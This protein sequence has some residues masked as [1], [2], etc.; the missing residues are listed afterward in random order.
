MSLAPLPDTLV[1]AHH[2]L[3]NPVS[4]EPD[5]GY[6]WLK[7]IGAMKPFGDP[8][9]IQRDY[10]LEEFRGE[11]SVQ[12]LA[13]SVHVQ[14]DGAIADPVAETRFIQSI[15]DTSG[16]PIAIVGFVDLARDDAGE[17][18][19]RHMESHNFRGLRQI[20]SRLEGRRDIS[21]AVEEYL[22]S[23]LWRRNYS[24]LAA[25]GLTFDLQCYPEQMA[26]FAEFASD[27]RD[28]PVVIDHAGSPYDQSPQGLALWRDG[29]TRLAALPNTSVKL[30]GFGMFDANWNAES[31]RPLV[32]H[33]DTVFGP[34]RTLFGSNFPVDRLMRSY[35]DI[36]A[37]LMGLYAAH[38]ASDRAAVF[39]GN[40]VRI[41]RMDQLAGFSSERM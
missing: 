8:T 39:G 33:I 15:S 36:L 7:N 29:M 23:P 5:V 30:S 22:D 25:H 28:I 38:T 31:I 21:F 3:W 34:H 41:Y 18:I 10:L 4:A 6:I 14:C 17:V 1:D 24:S 9:P 13:G 11:S 12:G 19:D 32:E 40:A 20:L 35:D 26:A 37:D 27:H 16:F 2:H